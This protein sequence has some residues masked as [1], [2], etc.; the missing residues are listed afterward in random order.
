VTLRVGVGS[1]HGFVL[2]GNL[3]FT[4]LH[5]FRELAQVDGKSVPSWLEDGAP[6]TV[7]SGKMAWQENFDLK[8]LIVT[9]PDK[10]CY[11]DLVCYVMSHSAKGFP[12][13]TKF[14]ASEAE[15]GSMQTVDDCFF[16]K[17]NCEDQDDRIT[18]LDDVAQNL[19]RIGWNVFPG[20]GP[21]D[22]YAAR[23]WLYDPR[24]KGDCGSLVMR[25]TSG[26]GKVIGMHI[27]GKVDTNEGVGLILSKELLE[28]YVAVAES[29]PNDGHIVTHSFAYPCRVAD[30]SYDFPTLEGEFEPIGK[31]VGKAGGLSGKS[32]FVKSAIA[33]LPDFPNCT[34]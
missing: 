10:G 4:N 17:P 9:Q 34:D 15:I 7:M 11:M 19:E 1:L 21:N 18:V 30:P 25:A 28:K 20:S 5:F 26:N 6:F 33:D 16:Q 14:F 32:Q 2:K 8:R 29:N 12:D 22:L 24:K 13:I 31:I 23:Y 27:A 3:L